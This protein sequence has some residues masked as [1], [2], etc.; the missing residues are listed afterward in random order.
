[1]SN[2]LKI[3]FKCD[4]IF[5]IN[6]YILGGGGP[7]LEGTNDNQKWDKL[8]WNWLTPRRI[9]QTCNKQDLRFSK[10]IERKLKDMKTELSQ[11]TAVEVIKIESQDQI[12]QKDNK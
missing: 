10:E 8:L 12:I 3:I 11:L 5:K 7:F 4:L 2:Y 6:F 9:N 1:M